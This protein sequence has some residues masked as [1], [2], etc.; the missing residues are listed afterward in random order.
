M[1]TE[2]NTEKNIFEQTNVALNNVG[3]LLIT[4]NLNE[5]EK[6][7]DAFS[8]LNKIR[9]QYLESAAEFVKKGL[10]DYRKLTDP[11]NSNTS[12]QKSID[13]IK[14]VVEIDKVFKEFVGA[15]IK[16]FSVYKKYSD[17]LVEVIKTTQNSLNQFTAKSGSDKVQR[18]SLLQKFAEHLQDL[19]YDFDLVLTNNDE[20]ELNNIA[21]I[22]NIK[23][24]STITTKALD[25]MT[26][27]LRE[28]ASQT[29]KGIRDKIREEMQK[30]EK[31]QTEV[32]IEALTPNDLNMENINNDVN[33]TELSTQTLPIDYSNQI[34]PS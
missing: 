21:L 3:T 10:N 26:D 4:L 28:I 17:L 11:K 30:M 29:Q 31:F 2:K 9:T 32:N 20:N 7:N 34:D 15:L 5:P 16:Y 1:N 6:I 12:T 13:I 22:E 25:S 8:S 27:K 14:K 33:N 23:N 19:K 24:A 18:I